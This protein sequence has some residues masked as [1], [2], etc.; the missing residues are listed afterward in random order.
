MPLRPPGAAR[1]VTRRRSWSNEG[2]SRS[3]AAAAA[4]VRAPSANGGP[5][6]AVRVRGAESGARSPSQL[7][8]RRRV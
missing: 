4:E 5:G 8:E 6:R 3:P 2:A 1:P 7:W